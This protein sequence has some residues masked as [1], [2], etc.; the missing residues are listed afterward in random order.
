MGF[1]E[2]CEELA[3]KKGISLNELG[4]RVGI[5]GPAITGWKNGSYPKLDVAQR[6]AEEF[7]VSIDY[8]ATGKYSDTELLPEENK[9]IEWYRKTG[10]KRSILE[11]AK[12]LSVVTTKQYIFDFD[13]KDPLDNGER[14]SDEILI[15]E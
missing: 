14:P 4:R 3:N 11:L 9:L 10:M 7:G 15:K 5:S 8:L 1:Y 6:V 12:Q 13:G 2:R